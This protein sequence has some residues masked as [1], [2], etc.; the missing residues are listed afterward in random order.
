MPRLS[1]I[2][3]IAPSAISIVPNAN[4]SYNDIAVYVTRGAKI[5][6]FSPRAGIDMS[7]NAYQEWNFSGRNRRLADSTVPYTVYARLDRKNRADG[8][9][10]FAPQKLVDN[11]WVDKYPSVTQ[12]GLTKNFY[13]R[14]IAITKYWFVRLGE[15]SLPENGQRILTFDTGI[16]DTDD[17]N[18]NWSL[19][20]DALPLRVEL[21]CTISDEDAGP[22]PYIY[23]GQL[24]ALSSNLVEG[25]TG[26]DIK[27]F[28]H[29]EITRNTDDAVADAA[30]NTGERART[31]RD[32]GVISL[33]HLRTV[34]DFNGAVSAIFTIT[35]M[36]RHENPEDPSNP[37]YA[38]LVSASINIHAETVEKYE[39][40]PST[41]IVSYNPQSG[42]YNPADGVFVRVRATDQSGYV[43]ELTNGQLANSRITVQYAV[44]DTG[45]WIDVTFGDVPTDTAVGNI[46]TSAF[47]A[48]KNVVIRILGIDASELTSL[49]ISF[50]RDGEDSKE[51]EWI[52]FR[53]VNPVVFVE[54]PGLHQKPAL[55]NGGEVNPTGAAT[56]EDTNKNQDGWVPENWWDDMQGTDE[57]HPYE[58]GSYRDFVR[59]DNN[60]NHWGSFSDP[61]IW[62]RYA[63]DAVTYDIVPSVSIINADAAGTIIS[64]GI[65]VR[66]YKTKGHV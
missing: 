59:D 38:P 33:R 64:D 17:F 13:E 10:I 47:S 43:C 21:G 31:I 32:T 36:E 28:D 41:T 20:P 46:P 14:T 53:S 44:A 62:S 58:Y 42:A 61:K 56:G 15:V 12:N 23:W 60:G 65:I 49:P 55:V 19:S 5:K 18:T 63:G 35:A 48:Q 7:D 3:Y 37:I 2:H 26:T 40:V 39:L 9:L 51:R 45:N 66:A 34:D 22:T 6:V 57:E 1:P 8:Y 30:W 11:E 27:R 16:L 29:W 54:E 4:G 24:L 25:W 52:F 50:V